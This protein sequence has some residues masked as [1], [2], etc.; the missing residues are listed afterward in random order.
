MRTEVVNNERF[1]D[2][3]EIAVNLLIVSYP[4]SL[5]LPFF[6]IVQFKSQLDD[7]MSTIAS[8]DTHYI[9]CIK[10]NAEKIADSFSGPF[11]L[12]QLRCSGMLEYV[13]IRQAGYGSRF[14]FSISKS[15]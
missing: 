12:S 9:R 1:L 2:K 13:Q 4:L 10:P 8:S 11:V 3:T 7:L 5:N 6:V 15:S 14:V